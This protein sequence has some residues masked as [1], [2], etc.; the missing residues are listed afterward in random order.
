MKMH[1][2]HVI[3]NVASKKFAAQKS[4][5]IIACLAIMLTT[6]MIYTVFSLGISF[7]QNMVLQAVQGHGTSADLLFPSPTTE[8][9]AV[10]EDC[11]LCSEVGLCVVAATLTDISDT[12]IRQAYLRYADDICWEKQLCPALLHIEGDYPKAENEIMMPRWAAKKL[13]LANPQIGQKIEL[14]FY[15]GYIFMR[16][17]RLSDDT[18]KTFV[19]SGLYDDASSVMVSNEAPMYISKSFLEQAPAKKEQYRSAAYITLK[20]KA[21]AAE[22]S[23]LLVLTNGQ[24]LQDLMSHAGE[25]IQDMIQIGAAVLLIILCGGLIIYNILYI[26]VTQDIQFLGQLKTLGMTKRQ[27]KKYIRCQVYWLCLIGILAGLTLAAL[28]SCFLVPLAL[29]SFNGKLEGINVSFSPI[30]FTGAILTS[31]VTVFLGSRKALKIAGSVSPISASKYT[32]IRKKVKERKR[33]QDSI[34]SFAW[35]NVFRNP[36]SAI[37]VF[38]SLFLAGTIFLSVSGL[39]SSVNASAMVSRSMS[40]DISVRDNYATREITEKV[41]N[42]IKEIAGVNHV[43][44]RMGAYAEDK[45]SWIETRDETLNKYCKSVLESMPLSQKQIEEQKHQY[46]KDSKYAVEMIGIGEWEFNYIADKYKLDID[47]DEFRTGEAGI[48]CYDPEDS[49]EKMS[50]DELTVWPLGLQGEKLSIAKMGKNP[51]RLTEFDRMNYIAPNIIVSN[52][53]LEGIEQS[54]VQEVVIMIKDEKYDKNVSDELE[55]IFQD[56][57][58][59]V[60][61]SK[62]EKVT[63][64][65]ESFSVIKT[66]GIS[67]SSILLVIGIMNF[68]NTIYSGILA[69]D[70]EFA[71]LECIGMSK[72]QL[73]WMLITEGMIYM[74][75]TVIL[76]VTLGNIIYFGA[77]KVFSSMTGW[78]EFHYPIYEIGFTVIGM[79][80]TIFTVP[81]LSYW[82]ISKDYAIEQLRKTD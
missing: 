3:R 25:R 19:I 75:I 15:Y 50:S 42:Q 69:R 40:Y 43:Y 29:N 79:F 32:N 8:Q 67:L 34:F 64:L 33:E 14:P 17:N 66:I 54:Y 55:S 5:N 37:V 39:L 49:N 51:V 52:E 11:G 38:L 46:N 68:I 56:S 72:N 30:I 74:A 80:L 22:L 65:T 13:G 18:E 24:E 48:W 57:Q 81:L 41:V 47:Y 7:R 60:I 62:L 26:S 73:K 76:I 35:R 28:V 21:D 70:K 23:N 10:L 44:I 59:I 61:E 71:M 36:K 1:N 58:G 45:L 20:E 4:R 27:L 9:L 16:Y 53:V 63:R 78:D 82:S 6:F 77:F 31:A 2:D 12:G